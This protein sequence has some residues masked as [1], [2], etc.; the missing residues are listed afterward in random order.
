MLRKLLNKFS[1]KQNKNKKW[2]KSIFL[3]SNSLAS[4]V[5]MAFDFASGL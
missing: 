3:G 2:A 1:T 5:W 4:N